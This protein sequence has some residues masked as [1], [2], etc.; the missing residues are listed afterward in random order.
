[1]TVLPL[2]DTL[3]GQVIRA[4]TLE[5]VLPERPRRYFRHGWQSWSLAAW[6]DAG[7]RFPVQRP[8]LLHPLQVDPAWAR[9]R[10]PHGS[11][12]GAAETDGDAVLLGSLGLET[13]VEL[14]GDRLRGTCENGDGEWTVCRGDPLSVFDAYAA[15][16]GPRL[17]AARPAGPAPRVWCSWYSLHTAIDER[18]VRGIFDRLE[19]LPFDVLQVDDG[20]QRAIGDW[21]ANG[22]FP[23]GMEALADSIRSTGRRAGL[24][25]APLIAGRS[26]RL[27][28][29]N[30]GWFLRDG[31][32]RLV[33]A[34][35]NWGEQLYALDTTRPAVLGWLRELMARVR[36][37]GFDYLKLDFLYG[38]ALPGRRAS[39]APREAAC[40]EAFLAMR[41]AMGRDAFFLA[42]GSPVLP[43]LGTCDGLRV[44]PDVAA[45]WESARDAVLFSNPSMPG[46]KNALRTAVNR[47]WL[48]PLVH[49]DPDVAFFAAAGCS[50]TRG[51]RHLVRMLAEV[52]RYKGTSDL[53]SWLTAEESTALRGFLERSPEI[54][55]RGMY[56]YS[57]G[58]EEVD[59]APAVPL[60]DPPRGL[61]ALGGAVLGW[62]AN[63]R[64]ALWVN[65]LLFESGWREKRA[66]T[67]RLLGIPGG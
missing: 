25:L 34:G 8:S 59:F 10:T 57:V 12:L 66:E 64:A 67:G 28:R 20:W 13:H 45:G 29:D 58:G 49:V 21:E 44:G 23:S 60:A 30:P 47:L 17:G 65:N 35:F 5:I 32:G 19:G 61:A 27:F 37:W 15:Q 26:S 36:G 51:Q 1:M 63:R 16:L 40:R 41:E 56:R 46:A 50:M 31:R 62:C 22:K 3:P 14:D 52:C 33:S 42:C 39:G 43:A 48:A 7:A 55:R 18:I 6:T 2:G 11:W 38:G 54:A 4:R 9:H 24:W 53:P